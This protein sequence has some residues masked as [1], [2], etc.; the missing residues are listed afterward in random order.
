MS[1]PPF[2]PA[3]FA[4][5]VPFATLHAVRTPRRARWAGRLLLLLF[6]LSP[7][8]LAFVP[9]QQ[10][11]NGRGQVVAYQPTERRQVIT[12]RVNGQIG[13]W[14]V[15]EQQPVKRGDPIVD[16]DDNDPELATRLREQKRFLQGRL[17]AADAE[18]A[19]QE[20]AVKAQEQAAKAAVGAARANRDAAVQQVAVA[21]NA[22]KIAEFGR[23]FRDRQFQMFDG[24]RAKG[25]ESGL[26]RD[27]AKMQ[28]DQAANDVERAEADILARKATVQTQEALVQRAEADGLA[29]VALANRELQRSIAARFAV[30]RELQ[31]IETQIQQFEARFVRAPVDGIIQSVTGNAGQGGQYVKQGDVLCEIV[32]DATDRVVELM[33]DGLDA[34]LV[35]AHM[36]QTGRGPHVRLQFEGWP[37]VQFTGWPSVAVGTFGGRVR[38]MDPTDD[39]AG[40]FRVLVEPEALWDGDEWPEGLFLRQ[41]NQAVG[42]VFLNRVTL[43]YELW[44]QF[45]GFPPVI[46]PKPPGKGGDKDKDKSK[47]PKIKL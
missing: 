7:V 25:L 34:P 21:E 9:W 27:Q 28:A 13:K 33:I 45:N 4:A 32:P 40:R 44:R 38:Q 47:P 18:I 41:G 17:A 1:A 23:W 39:G 19:Q 8:A 35:A 29:A 43:G 2:P 42:W 11:V 20:G 24:L 10:T 16:I 12:A 36:K 31:Q 22:K 26:S 37:A 5:D 46:A 3:P 14:H 6:V 15:A 30:E